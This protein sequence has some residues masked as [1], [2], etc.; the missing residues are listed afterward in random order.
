MASL[1]VVL[2]GQ[3]DAIMLWWL[4][5]EKLLESSNATD[6]TIVASNDNHSNNMGKRVTV[7]VSRNNLTSTAGLSMTFD[8]SPEASE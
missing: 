1:S 6:V 3:E 8:T 5:W 2:A 4:A 7:A